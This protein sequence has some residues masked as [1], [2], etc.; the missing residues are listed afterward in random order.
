MTPLNYIG[1]I[2]II[3]KLSF[4]LFFLISDRIFKAR[5]EE[6]LD[7]ITMEE[8]AGHMISMFIYA[9]LAFT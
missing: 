9:A 1:I 8:L 4:M 2:L 7:D 5:G 3:A 6:G